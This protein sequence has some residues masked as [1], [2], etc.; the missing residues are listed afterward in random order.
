MPAKCNKCGSTDL[1]LQPEEECS[2]CASITCQRRFVEGNICVIF[3]NVFGYVIII[4][5]FSIW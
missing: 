4:F 1:S 5:L 2:V 3:R